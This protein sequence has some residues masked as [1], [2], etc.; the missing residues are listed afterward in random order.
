MIGDLKS[1]I[2]LAKVSKEQNDQETS[3]LKNLR[4]DKLQEITQA[5]RIEETKEEI[6]RKNLADLDR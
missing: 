4:Q 6:Y 1:E 3:R 5:I 2:D